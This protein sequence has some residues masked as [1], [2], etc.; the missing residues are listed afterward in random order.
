MANPP[1]YFDKYY[2]EKKDD[3]NRKRKDRYHNDPDYR[4]RVLKASRDYRDKKRREQGPRVRMPRHQIPLVRR[5]QGGEIQLFSV[6]FFAL[7]LGRSVQSLNHWEK[8]EPYPLLPVTPYRD[9]RGFRYYTIEMMD[10]VKR[11]IG[12]K[13]RLFPVDRKMF[14]QIK[15][16]WAELGVPVNRKSLESAL[17]GTVLKRKA[18]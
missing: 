12:K 15:K 18:S 3:I 8:T 1:G 2:E 16:G 11:V 5:V 13:R 7:R 9:E 4:K 6:G 17:E 14:H 10:V